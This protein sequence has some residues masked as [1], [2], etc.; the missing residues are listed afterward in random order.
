[1]PYFY[2]CA[3]DIFKDV[4]YTIVV[5]TQTI[6][7]GDARALLQTIPD[8]T[9]RC[10]VTS[11]PYFGLRDYG[12]SEQIGLESSLDDYIN[13]LVTVF[14]EVRRVLTPDGTFWLNIGDSYA[15]SGRGPEGNLGKDTQSRHVGHKRQS[16]VPTGMKPKDLMGVPWMLAAALRKDGW[17]LRSD[18]I[19]AKSTSGQRDY[20]KHVA[21][22]AVEAQI[23]EAQI[24]A[25]LQHLD[26][27][28][29]TTMPESVKDRPTRAHEHIFLLSKTR[30]Y[31]YDGDALKEP[32]IFPAGTKAAK[33]SAKRAEAAGVNSRPPVYAIYSGTRQIR[34]VWAINPASYKGAHFATFPPEFVRMCILAGSQP[35]DTVL[36]P[37]LGAG[38]TMTVAKQHGR[39]CIG[40]ELNPEYVELSRARVA[41]I[42]SLVP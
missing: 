9:I 34:D 16:V 7:Q 28:V 41:E 10:C 1:M 24:A 38:T 12:M 15:G 8:N 36:D 3:V 22:A 42:D 40:M 32:G 23:P 14:R 6:L 20:L 26:L 35:G 27:P 11:P 18:I 37:F 33:G 31:Y 29:G 13:E 21:A 39:A 4:L 30:Q 25:L 19:W 17:Y 5:L 2:L